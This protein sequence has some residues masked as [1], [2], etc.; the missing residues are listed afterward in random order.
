MP[1]ETL[2]PVVITLVWEGPTAAVAAAFAVWANWDYLREVT[3]REAKPRLASWVI[4]TVAMTVGSAGAARMDQWP[5]AAFGF[6]SAATCGSVVVAGWRRG[7]KKLTWLDGFALL[8]GGA[9]IALLTG[10]MLWPDR[11]P[12]T[13]VIGISVLTDLCAFVPTYDNARNGEE[14][15]RPYIKDTIGAAAALA[16][17][18]HFPQPVGVIYPAYQ[19]VTCAAAAWLAAVGKRRHVTCCPPSQ[20]EPG[21][22]AAI[23]PP[24]PPPAA[25]APAPGPSGRRQPER[26]VRV[27]ERGAL[28]RQ[29]RRAHVHVPALAAALRARGQAVRGLAVPARSPAAQPGGHGRGGQLI[30]HRVLR[31]KLRQAG[32]LRLLRGPVPLPGIR[33]ISTGHRDLRGGL[34]GACALLRTGP[35][36]LPAPAAGRVPA[37][38]GRLGL[39]PALQART[40]LA[41]RHV[42]RQSVRSRPLPRRRRPVP[43]QVR[44][45]G[46]PLLALP[47]RP[48]PRSAALRVVR[49]PPRTPRLS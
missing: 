7:D 6:A 17:V 9:G 1:A 18:R 32:L 39:A 5:A 26:D 31:L 45:R 33:I 34:S 16:G 2:V 23:L 46:V 11:F 49:V 3:K 37:R 36:L 29:A 21:P 27:R 38:G 25:P 22:T 35:A 19:M 30:Q 15:P 48:G 44:V 43:G 41:A 20:P 47:A 4:W 13:V 24:R 42:R 8:A 10:A 14:V 12:M 28:G 40:A